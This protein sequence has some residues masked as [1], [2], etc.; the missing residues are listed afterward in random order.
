MKGT[1]ML[2]AY[3]MFESARMMMAPARLAA[4]LTRYSLQVP[5]NP[6]A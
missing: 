6:L 1:A 4:D 2:L 5:G 3:G